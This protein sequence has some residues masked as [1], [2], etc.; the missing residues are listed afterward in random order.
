MKGS[1]LFEVS[2]KSIL[3]DASN[4]RLLEFADAAVQLMG[5]E[6]RLKHYEWL[7]CYFQ[8]NA[9][10][11]NELPTDSIV[12]SYMANRVC[13]RFSFTHPQIVAPRGRIALYVN[14]SVPNTTIAVDKNEQGVWMVRRIRFVDDQEM[15]EHEAEELVLPLLALLPPTVPNDEEAFKR[16]YLGSLRPAIDSLYEAVSAYVLEHKLNKTDK[17]FNTVKIYVQ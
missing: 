15:I 12:M 10:N 8:H 7:G 2:A 17:K 5:F 11:G 16:F 6:T 3:A 4:D 9:P 14:S 1:S 13:Q